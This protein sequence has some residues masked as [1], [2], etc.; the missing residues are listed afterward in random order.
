MAQDSF[1]GDLG[2]THGEADWSGLASAFLQEAF[3]GFP[4][5]SADK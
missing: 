1:A 2:P 3:G 5:C 4:I